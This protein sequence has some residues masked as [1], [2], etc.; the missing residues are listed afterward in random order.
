[1][2][3]RTL[4]DSDINAIAEAV[5]NHE[6]HP[7][8]FSAI[9]PEDLAESVKFYKNF[10]KVLTETNSVMRKTIIVLLMTFL[11]GIISSGIAVAIKNSLRI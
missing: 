11:A 10:N 7:C 5:L 2:P 1:M 3:D 6:S 8:R 4:S 9:S